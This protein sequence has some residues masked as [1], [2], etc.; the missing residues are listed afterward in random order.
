MCEY[1]LVHNEILQDNRIVIWK[2]NKIYILDVVN[3]SVDPKDVLINSSAAAFLSASKYQI[4]EELKMRIKELKSLKSQLNIV[5]NSNSEERTA[6][7]ASNRD[8]LIDLLTAKE[9]KSIFDHGAWEAIEELFNIVKIENKESKESYL[10]DLNG[11]NVNCT[12]NGY[13]IITLTF[14]F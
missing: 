8:E 12:S 6:G 7:K 4:D 9:I 13:R 11:I 2:V 5:I 1:E 14:Y 3:K 10:Y